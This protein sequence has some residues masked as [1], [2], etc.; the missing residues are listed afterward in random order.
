MLTS[1]LLVASLVRR[2]EDCS[3]VFL[4]STGS[5]KSTLINCLLEL[6][7]ETANS[8]TFFRSSPEKGVIDANVSQHKYDEANDHFKAIDGL[9]PNRKQTFV[10]F[11]LFLSLRFFVFVRFEFD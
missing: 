8:A 11:S 5:G 10:C 3:I 6:T 2:D 7:V 4:G 9:D 1:C